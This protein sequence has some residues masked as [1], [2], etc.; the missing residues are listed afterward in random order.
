M[1][2]KV[3]LLDDQDYLQPQ[4]IAELPEQDISKH[5]NFCWYFHTSQFFE[6]ACNNSAILQHHRDDP[7][8]QHIIH[9]RK[10]FEETLRSIPEGTQFVVA[11]DPQGEGQPFLYQRQNRIRDQDGKVNAYVEGNWYNQGLR[12]LMAPSVLDVVQARLVGFSFTAHA[13]VA[14]SVQFSISTRLQQISDLSQDMTHW[15]PAT[16]HSYFPSSIDA[17]KAAATASRIGSPTLAPTDLEQAEAA[18]V[19][20]AETL[21][22]ATEFSD[23]F[24]LQSLNLTNRY[25]DEYMDENPLKGE[26]GAFVFTNTKNAVDERNKAQEQLAQATAIQLAAPKADT[27]PPSVAPSAAP[28]PKGAPTPGAMEA[29]S[30]KSSTNTMPKDKK[31]ER[32]KSKGLA[33]PTTPGAPPIG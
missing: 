7:A 33:S 19:Q 15:T 29:H 3:P 6:A 12:V 2:T 23:A 17:P 22:S 16:G 31:R 21:D 11:A 26:P 20:P 24:F 28:T 14:N 25:G 18:T 30:R 10:V 1:A 27:Q 4:A 32:R 8:T 5:N 9:D 13:G